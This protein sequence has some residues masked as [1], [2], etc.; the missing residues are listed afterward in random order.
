MLIHLAAYALGQPVADTTPIPAPP[1][2]TSRSTS[3][4]ERL[5]LLQEQEQD[6]RAALEWMR[7]SASMKYAFKDFDVVVLALDTLGEGQNAWRT[8]RNLKPTQ[9]GFPAGT[10]NAGYTLEWQPCA[11]HPDAPLAFLVVAGPARIGEHL[12]EPVVCGDE[13]MIYN[14]YIYAYTR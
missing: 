5:V 2:S 4:S 13:K 12:V 8:C 1:G 14:K 9:F 7:L 10:M 11:E 6:F 3:V